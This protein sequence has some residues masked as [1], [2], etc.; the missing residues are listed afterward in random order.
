MVLGL[1]PR[2]QAKLMN[3]RNKVQQPPAPTPTTSPV[4]H[5]HSFLA[6]PPSWVYVTAQVFGDMKEV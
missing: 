4:A 2:H 1:R 6:S 5:T 3:V